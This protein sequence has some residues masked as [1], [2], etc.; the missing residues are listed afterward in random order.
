MEDWV[1]L[2]PEECLLS[3]IN[4]RYNACFVLAFFNIN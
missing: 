2:T 3:L 1:Y 4:L